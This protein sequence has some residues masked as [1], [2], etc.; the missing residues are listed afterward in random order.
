M[1]TVDEATSNNGI[2][3]NGDG[4]S[5]DYTIEGGYIGGKILGPF[6]SFFGKLLGIG[7]NKAVGY[8]VNPNK[9]NYFFGRVVTGSE[10]NI[11]RSAQNLADLTKLGI[12]N[13]NQ[14]LGVFNEAM[15]RGIVVANKTNTF[16]VTVVKDV[17]IGNLG[18][19]NVGFFYE[20]GV[21][22]STPSVS[23]IIPK[24]FK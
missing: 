22:T 12:K 9:F 16:G 2:N 8:T 13:E 6:V 24:I 17:V 3:P 1:P 20:G 5:P 10:H 21:M 18:S 15:E 14:L 19:V 23:T 7:L 4:I 11:A